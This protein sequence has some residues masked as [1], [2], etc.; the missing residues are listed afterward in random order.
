MPTTRA[1]Y[2]L[3]VKSTTPGFPGLMDDRIGKLLL[4]L[5][6]SARLYLEFSAEDDDD[7][8]DDTVELELEPEPSPSLYLLKTAI[9]A[10]CA[11]RMT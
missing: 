10:D 6:C 11:C 1:L 4:L 5:C 9:C 2:T 3:L 8:E 7:D